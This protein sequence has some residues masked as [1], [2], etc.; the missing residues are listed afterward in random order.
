LRARAPVSACLLALAC[1]ACDAIVGV[2]D[3]V[4]GDASQGGGIDAGARDARADRAHPVDVA[5]PPRDAGHDSGMS[6][7][8]ASEA[9]MCTAATCPEGCCDQSGTCQPNTDTMCGN[10][11]TCS[12]CF[13]NLGGIACRSGVCGCNS[14][15]DC[16]WGEA[17]TDVDCLTA[18]NQC[19][20][21]S[22][23]VCA[24]GSECCSGS[25]PGGVCM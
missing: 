20:L 18:T 15:T 9:A 12:N 7:D 1:V 5:A 3:I 14:S 2:S 23:V 21:T 6:A 8:A 4:V 25:C 17:G 11:S 16:P 13:F 22:G 10:G 24:T 19:C